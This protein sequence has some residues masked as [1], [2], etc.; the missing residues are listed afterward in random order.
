MATQCPALF[1]QPAKIGV[2]FRC[3][4]RDIDRRNIG[5]SECADAL[6]CR[7]TGHVFGPVRP[8]IDMAVPTDLIAEFADIDLKDRDPGGAK[9]EQ[10]DSIELCL[11]GWAASVVLPSIFNCSVEEARGLC[12]P[13]QGQRHIQCLSERESTPEGP[14]TISVHDRSSS[15][16]ILETATR[17]SRSPGPVP[18]CSPALVGS[19]ERLCSTPVCPSRCP[20]DQPCVS[21]NTEMM[22]GMGLRAF[23][24]L[25]KILHTVLTDEQGF[26]DTQPRFVAQGLE[27]RGAL[28]RSQH[29]AARR[30][31]HQQQAPLS[32]AQATASPLTCWPAR[33]MMAK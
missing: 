16:P 5:L 23:Q 10:A 6:L 26:Q 11:E 25:N 13:R 20:L 30:R 24:Y 3:A 15:T 21:E 31:L 33:L 2:E 32:E 8:R 7:F 18:A 14:I 29:L 9:R 17:S 4:T 12:W 19:W 22:G 27:H 28:A 1:N